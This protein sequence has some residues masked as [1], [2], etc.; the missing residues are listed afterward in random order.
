MQNYFVISAMGV[1][2]PG[3]VNDFSKAI[4]NCGCNIADSRMTV[5]G[6]EF[7]IIMMLAGNW[8]AIAKIEDAIPRLQKKL[9]LTI[10]SKRTESRAA[11][12][13]LLPYAID[14]VSMDHPGIVNEIA[15]FFSS[16][17]INI[18][19][20]FTGT[21][22]AAHTGTTMFSLHMTISIPAGMSIA[23]L[24]SDFLEFCDSL[25]LDAMMEPAK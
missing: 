15:N 20:L 8:D 3:I 13:D 4:L 18:E 23:S 19:D 5:L 24:R 2:R 12:A 7:A 16:R 21:Y 10:I 14:V 22:L 6:G 11:K 25:N 17:Q 1:D 9:G